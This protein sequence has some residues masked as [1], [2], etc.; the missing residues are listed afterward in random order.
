MLVTNEFRLNACD[1]KSE[2]RADFDDIRNSKNSNRKLRMKFKF[3]TNCA[4][5]P[6]QA[7]DGPVLQTSNARRRY[8]FSN[9][10]DKLA[11][12]THST[13]T[14]AMGVANGK[15]PRSTANEGSDLSCKSIYY[16]SIWSGC[17]CVGWWWPLRVD[18]SDAWLFLRLCDWKNLLNNAIIRAICGVGR[19]L[20]CIIYL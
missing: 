11:L 1:P 14:T 9:L 3:A 2:Q 7:H 6:A 18:A 13:T 8:W 15:F 10:I 5:L 20:T 12:H 17:R 19:W 16:L 4:N